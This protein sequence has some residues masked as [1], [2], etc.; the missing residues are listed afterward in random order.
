MRARTEE[1]KSKM[2]TTTVRRRR[3]RKWMRRIKRRNNLLKLNCSNYNKNNSSNTGTTK[4]ISRLK[5]V[6]NAV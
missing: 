6:P 2:T 3:R 4:L 1:S 5:S